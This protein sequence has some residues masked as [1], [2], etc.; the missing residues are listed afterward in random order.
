MS[1]NMP[2]LVAL[3][4][5]GSR[6]TG[7]VFAML[8]AGS[9]NAADLPLRINVTPPSPPSQSEFDRFLADRHA[10][11]ASEEARKKLFQEFLLWRKAREHR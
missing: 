11:P 5:A 8:V 2:R 10:A 9:G 6:L 7:L 4:R 3:K 1:G